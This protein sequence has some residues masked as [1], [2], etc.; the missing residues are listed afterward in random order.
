MIMVGVRPIWAVSRHAQDGLSFLAN[1]K[2]WELL[3]RAELYRLPRNARPNE[4]VGL[5]GQ[6]EFRPLI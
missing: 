1:A 6:S 4:L 2:V 5:Q 3:F